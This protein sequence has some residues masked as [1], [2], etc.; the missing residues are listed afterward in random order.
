MLFYHILQFVY[1]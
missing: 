1:E